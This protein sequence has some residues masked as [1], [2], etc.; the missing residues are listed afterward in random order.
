M[1]IVDRVKNAVEVGRDEYHR[2]L[3]AGT[4]RQ[5]HGNRGRYIYD[6][7]VVPE[8]DWSDS[9]QR[10]PLTAPADIYTQKQHQD[11][12]ARST[13]KQPAP[14]L[15]PRVDD[16]NRPMRSEMAACVRAGEYA[17]GRRRSAHEVGNGT[18][19][20]PHTHLH[21]Q[22]LTGQPA[23]N[24]AIQDDARH[25]E[26]QQPS[27]KQS[28]TVEQARAKENTHQQPLFSDGDSDSDSDEER[29]RG[30]LVWTS[31]SKVGM[32]IDDV[33]EQTGSMTTELDRTSSRQRNSS[34]GRLRPSEAWMVH[35]TAPVSVDELTEMFMEN[36]D[37]APDEEVGD[38]PP[39]QGTRTVYQRELEPAARSR[40][41]VPTTSKKARKKYRGKDFGGYLPDIME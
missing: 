4:A 35:N 5:R 33:N 3:D 9:P 11:Q 17:Q 22:S 38:Q 30:S 26:P 40:G 32:W 1:G 29:T 39:R 10:H 27:R 21:D 37:L 2:R 19:G 20:E 6:R 16:K 18:Q 14:S 7:H 41:L 13:T 31:P 12:G 15:S 28:P 36:M 25:T 24:L 23:S 34:S 8:E